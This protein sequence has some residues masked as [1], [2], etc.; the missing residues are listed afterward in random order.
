MPPTD[1]GARPRTARG[2]RGGPL[3]GSTRDLQ[4]DPLGLLMRAR[5][6]HGDVV[7]FRY[8][9]PFAWYLFAHPD[10]VEHILVTHPQDFPKGVFGRVLDLIIPNGLASVDDAV[11]ARQR[12]MVQPGLHGSAVA[13]LADT[14]VD[15]T[16]EHLDRWRA[17]TAGGRAIDMS[18]AILRLSLDIA[19]RA[20]LGS[21]LGEGVDVLRHYADLALSQLDYRVRHPL[22]PLAFLPTPRALRYQRAARHADAAIATIVARRRQTP[23]AP[24]D[25]LTMLLSAEDAEGELASDEEIRDQ[26]KTLLIT[27]YETSGMTLVWF[28]YNLSLR[29]EIERRVREEVT[30]IAGERRPTAADLQGL[31]YTRQVLNETLRLYPPA[32]WLGRQA[33]Q[34]CEINGCR[35][36]RGTVVSISPFVTHRHPAFWSNPETFDPDRFLPEAV[37]GRPRGAYFPFGAGPRYCV[38]QAFA[39][40]EILLVIATVLPRWR[41]RLEP[42]AEV[43]IRLRGTL[44]AAPGLPMTLEPA[45]LEPVTEAGAPRPPATDTSGG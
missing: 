15:A 21:D 44:Q 31:T 43:R 17:A 41:L 20:L 34:A 2:P 30:A 7:R 40:L 6:E 14:I 16:I 11:W 39:L 25:L 28:L 1:T 45:P 19:G 23:D 42:G 8:F 9:G 4:R 26:V 10:D 18:Q 5:A 13:G 29:P 3:F 12:R 36:P 33:R 27:G 37:R 35:V 38:G 24:H 22:S 32:P